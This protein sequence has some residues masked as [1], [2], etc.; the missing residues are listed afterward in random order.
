MRSALATIDSRMRGELPVLRLAGTHSTVEVAPQGAHVIDWSLPGTQPVL[1][2]SPHSAFLRG[3]AIR[4]GVPLVFPWFGPSPGTAGGPQHG[5]ARVRDWSARSMAIGPEGDCMAVL[6]L[7]DDERTRL[8]WPHPFAARLTLRAGREL[9]LAL[10][11]KNSGAAAFAFE[12]ALHTYFAVSDVRDVSLV[13]LEHA[14]YLDKTAPDEAG[15]NARRREG[16][17]PIRFTGETDRV[18]VDTDSTCTIDDPGWRRRIV[19]AKQ[20]SRTTVVWNP[21]VDKA[22]AMTDLGDQA[23]SRMLCVESAVAGEDARRLAPGESH[24]LEAVIR[25]EQD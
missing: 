24:I 2:T 5:F 23:W 6:A 3:K 1:F 15:R 18:Y 20:G 17:S 19:V 10:E 4:G 13:G 9:R 11:I 16:G 12:A 7:D 25:V 21:W 22:R 8:A 14:G